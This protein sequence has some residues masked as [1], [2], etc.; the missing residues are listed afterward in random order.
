MAQA[1][2]IAPATAPETKQI[3]WE[4]N[5]SNARESQILQENESPTSQQ[6][7]P[8]INN[9]RT[10]FNQ[11]T[12]A[13]PPIQNSSITEISHEQAP[14]V[15]KANANNDASYQEYLRNYYKYYQDQ[16]PVNNIATGKLNLNISIF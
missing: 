5:E 2:T 10:R 6:P 11:T 1:V 15:N 8:D 3:E 12:T 4:V 13:T 7:Y 14:A 16:P 9:A